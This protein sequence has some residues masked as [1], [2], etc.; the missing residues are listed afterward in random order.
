MCFCFV[1]VATAQYSGG[2]LPEPRNAMRSLRRTVRVN[3]VLSLREVAEACTQLRGHVEWHT[4]QRR[5]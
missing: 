1:Y 4:R 5:V 3:V 2:G